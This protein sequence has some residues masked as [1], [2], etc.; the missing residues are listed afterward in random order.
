[1]DSESTFTLE[2]GVVEANHD[3]WTD[4]YASTDLVPYPS[5]QSDG[6]FTKSNGSWSST[7]MPIGASPAILS[8]YWRRGILDAVRGGAS[9]VFRNGSIKSRK[10]RPTSRVFDHKQVCIASRSRAARPAIVDFWN[11]LPIDMQVKKCDTLATIS[12]LS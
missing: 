11:S 2:E 3:L 9:G 10:A 6:S 4:T 1:M 8:P 5:Q 12:F 7:S